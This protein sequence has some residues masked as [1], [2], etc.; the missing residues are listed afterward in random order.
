M[1]SCVEGEATAAI[2]LQTAARL[3]LTLKHSDTITPAPQEESTH[4]AAK[5][6]AYDDD[7][8]HKSYCFSSLP[9]I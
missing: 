4:Q 6:T 5:A 2:A 8:L 1:E 7:T 3:A 9:F